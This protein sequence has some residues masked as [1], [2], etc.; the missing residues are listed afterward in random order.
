MKSCIA[1]N[2]TEFAAILKCFGLNTGDK[3]GSGAFSA[4]YRHPEGV[5]KFTVDSLWVDYIK[6]CGHLPAAPTP[7]HIARD[8]LRYRGR[9]MSFVLMPRY[10]AVK[11]NSKEGQYSRS[12]RLIR[13]Q[14]QER[15]VGSAFMS[16]G[17][18]S[19]GAALL[20]NM[21][22]RAKRPGMDYVA[23]TLIGI[24]RFIGRHPQG[25][26]IGVDMHSGNFLFDSVAQ[27]LILA[28]PLVMTD[29]PVFDRH[30]DAQLV[31]TGEIA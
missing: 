4:V 14:E 16:V 6:A 29:H 28:D 18:A 20:N 15:L 25:A 19:F 12:L 9:P 26:L 1:T 27:R 10:T 30:N 7:L 31:A 5:A 22:K 17:N 21:W 8:V 2:S 23:D 3:V 13:A 24:A 11:P